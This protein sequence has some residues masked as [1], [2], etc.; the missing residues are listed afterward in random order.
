MDFSLKAIRTFD[1]GVLIDVLTTEEI[2]DSISEDGATYESLRFDVI[3]EFWVELTVKGE[4]IGV[5]NFKPM[6]RHTYD[7]HIHILPEHRKKHSKRAGDMLLNWCDEH[8]PNSLFIFAWQMLLIS[9]L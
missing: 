1:V 4:T 8:L 9:L 5:A 6:F 7:C 3:N 2:F